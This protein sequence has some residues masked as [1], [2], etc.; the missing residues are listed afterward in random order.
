MTRLPEFGWVIFASANAVES[1]FQ[2]LEKQGRDSRAFAGTN[3]GAIGPATAAAL[4]VFEEA[5]LR[6]VVKIMVGGAPLSQE[7][8]DDFGADGYGRDAIDCVD[9]AKRFLG[10]GEPEEEPL[11]VPGS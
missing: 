4:Q 6:D 7:F 11:A 2:R 1:V 3:I 5:G 8:A 9:I 10:L